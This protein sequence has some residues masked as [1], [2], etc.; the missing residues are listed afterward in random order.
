M[1]SHSASPLFNVLMFSAFWAFQIFIAK[2]GFNAGAKVLPFQIAS[3]LA[4]TLLL[5][6]LILPR[7]GSNFKVLLLDSPDVFWRLFLANGIQA[8]LGTCLSIIGIALTDA[9]NAGFLVKLSTVTT[10]LF[11]WLIL[12]ETISNFKT[13]V[14]V[15]M[16]FGAYLLTTKGQALLPSPGDLFILGACVC[17]SL[18]NVM[19]RKILRSQTVNPD[20]VTLQKPFASLPVIFGLAGVSF[21]A[22]ALFSRLNDTLACCNFSLI[23]LP[24]AIGSGVCLAFAWIY[25]YRTLCIAT[26]SYMTLMSMATPVIVSILAMIFLG[27]KMVPVQ[28]LGGGLIIL[29]GLAIYFSDIAYS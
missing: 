8:G 29:S 21:Y 5:A 27:E 7:V 3:V 6:I 1:K 19:V 17:W 20:V 4:A 26:A 28:L 23:Y 16:I 12:K 11:A 15:M 18:G 14:V 9:V 10:I 24:Y 25:L 2:L 13:I 22:P